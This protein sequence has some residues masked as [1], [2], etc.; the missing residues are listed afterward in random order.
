MENSKFAQALLRRREEAAKKATQ[1]SISVSQ[2]SEKSIIS[3]E[4]QSIDPDIEVSM[5]VDEDQEL[6]QLQRE[7]QDLKAK[8]RELMQQNKVLSQ[9][10][11][12]LL[13]Q[14]EIEILTEQVSNLQIELTNEKNLKKQAEDRLLYLQYQ[15]DI[16]CKEAAA[17]MKI[18]ESLQLKNR[19]LQEQNSSL[20]QIN[21]SQL[22]S[23]QYSNGSRRSRLSNG[24]MPDSPRRYQPEPNYQQNYQP[25]ESP[26]RF[27]AEPSSPRR[28]Q[29]ELPPP[30]R[31]QQDLPNPS[32]YQDNIPQNQPRYA[33]NSARSSNSSSNSRNPADMEYD[34]LIRE[35]DMLEDKKIELENIMDENFDD[36]D[37][38]ISNQYNR[39]L[40]RLSQ[41]KRE[42]RFRS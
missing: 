28:Y 22:E 10:I 17:N 34:D 16:K 42:L 18:L 20:S 40:T 3:V 27:Q 36:V 1:T 24:Q 35:R 2:I 12:D 37:P 26:K 5:V 14:S 29:E 6:F 11:D 13:D 21:A 38:N 33:P 39:V 23:D 32:M 30:S 25:P 31:I 7:N 9:K 8:I 15:Y 4:E 19:K 41:V